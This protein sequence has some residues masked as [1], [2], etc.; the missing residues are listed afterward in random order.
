VKK[1]KKKPSMYDHSV[2][3]HHSYDQTTLT[4]LIEESKVGRSTWIHARSIIWNTEIN[5][6]TYFAVSTSRRFCMEAST[7]KN[8]LAR[9]V[10]GRFLKVKLN[11]CWL[12]LGLGKMKT[13]KAARCVI[14]IP[15]RNMVLSFTQ[16]GGRQNSTSQPRLWCDEQRIEQ[17]FS[18]TL[19][20]MPNFRVLWSPHHLPARARS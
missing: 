17:V 14:Q 11:S 6:Y 8:W 15:H 7:R 20:T 2:I 18:L 9:E 10:H 5:S 16:H 12:V 3:D 13:K 1:Q 19:K 4:C